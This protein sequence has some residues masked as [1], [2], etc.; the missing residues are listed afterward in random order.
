[1]PIEFVTILEV[2]SAD[3][4]ALATSEVCGGEPVAGELPVP[5]PAVKKDRT[6]A[7]NHIERG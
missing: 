6:A 5:H 2:S 7:A 3:F 1:M 4:F